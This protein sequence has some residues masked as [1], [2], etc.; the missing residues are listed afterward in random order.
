MSQILRVDGDVYDHATQLANQLE[1]LCLFA[2]VARENFE[3]LAEDA[4]DGIQSLTAD[5]TRALHDALI[6][7]RR[8][9]SAVG[10]GQTEISTCA[11]E[12]PQ[13]INAAI[14]QGDTERG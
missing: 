4:R 14:K 1:A 13:H 10:D 7:M 2:S 9:V 6:D 12:I 8:I 3:G 5:L 11:A